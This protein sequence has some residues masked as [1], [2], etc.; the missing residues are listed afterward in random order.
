VRAVVQR[1]IESSVQI[2]GE[3]VGAIG[4]GLTV[5]LGVGTDDDTTDA[6]YIADKVAGLRCFNDDDG[7]FDLTVEDVG[8][9]IL[10][11]SQFTLYGDCRKGRRPSFTQAGPPETA[12]ALYEAVIDLWRDRG[13]A[14]EMGRF[15][16]QMEVHLINDGPVT[17]L[18]DSKKTF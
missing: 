3:T 9:A 12:E 6:Q 13:L 11:I 1:V 17:L 5:F 14:V 2:A 4:P 7:K 10:A 15:R 8:G 18:I 16:A